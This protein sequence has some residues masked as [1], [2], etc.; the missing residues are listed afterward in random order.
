[1][2]PVPVSEDQVAETVER[3]YQAVQRSIPE[4]KFGKLR[5]VESLLETLRTSSMITK[6]T[7]IIRRVRFFNYLR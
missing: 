5:V 7:L 6:L 3:I 2:S 1:M 4:D